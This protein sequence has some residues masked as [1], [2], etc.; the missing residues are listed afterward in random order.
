[1]EQQE[2]RTFEENPEVLEG[3]LRELTVQVPGRNQILVIEGFP[4]VTADPKTIASLR[5]NPI[6][7]DR[8]AT[9]EE[10]NS[11]AQVVAQ[12]EVGANEEDI[13]ATP[14]AIEEAAK[15][16]VDLR[17]VKGTGEDGRITLG[18]VEDAVEEQGE[19]DTGTSYGEGSTGV[20]HPGGA[21]G[22]VPDPPEVKS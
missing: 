15:H 1:M 4:Y 17:Q 5:Q 13:D 9:D 11:L 12:E 21:A 3:E 8:E 16:G 6:L 10:R 14:R 19:T 7:T 18:D 2:V 20:G 22:Q